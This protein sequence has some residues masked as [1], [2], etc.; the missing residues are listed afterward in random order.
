MGPNR[1]PISAAVAFLAASS[2]CP[3]A[4]ANANAD[5]DAEKFASLPAKAR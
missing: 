2:A 4:N 5:S 1:P 3:T